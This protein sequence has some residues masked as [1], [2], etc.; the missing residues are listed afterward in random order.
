MNADRTHYVYEAR[1]ADGVV[2]YVGCTKRPLARHHEHMAGN[3][4]GRGW[5]QDRAASWTFSGP[6]PI[7]VARRIE[8]ERIA[9]EQPVYNGTSLGNRGGKRELI[10]E[11]RRALLANPHGAAQQADVA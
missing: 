3:G 4:E 6:Y 1:D 9:T 7:A 10:A 2:L 8:H 5:F 11:Y